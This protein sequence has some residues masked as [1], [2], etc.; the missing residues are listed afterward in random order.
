MNTKRILGS[1]AFLTAALIVPLNVNASSESEASNFSPEIR[2]ELKEGINALSNLTDEALNQLRRG[3]RDLSMDLK[4]RRFVAG[5]IT[6][7]EANALTNHNPWDVTASAVATLNDDLVIGN[8]NIIYAIN[9]ELENKTS[10]W[11]ELRTVEYELTVKETI[12]ITNTSSTGISQ[13]ISV[14]VG[15]PGASIGSETTV[16]VDFSKSET[17]TTE[18]TVRIRVPAQ[19]V[20]VPPGGHYKLIWT[21]TAGRATGTMN[22]NFN[23]NA[24]IPTR[25]NENGHRGGRWLRD[26]LEIH[27]RLARENPSLNTPFNREDWSFSNANHPVD[28]RAGAARYEVNESAALRVT[29]IDLKTGREISS[30]SDNV[31]VTPV[32]NWQ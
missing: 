18:R 20:Q 32:T 29:V 30:T 8:G 13:S 28:Y 14:E 21:L 16:S 4:L 6:A 10:I 9:N 2:E 17:Q 31:E 25:L 27:D 12:S 26:A 23:V 1:A 3:L 22:L 5:E 11:Q 24:A 19:S 15:L 7:A